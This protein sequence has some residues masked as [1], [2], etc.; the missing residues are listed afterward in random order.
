MGKR[1]TAYQKEERE[2][3]KIVQKIRKFEKFHSQNL[4]ER[5]C[6]R[7]KNLNYQKKSAE[8]K[9]KELQEELDETKKKLRK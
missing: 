2:V 4:I 3:N 8:N 9:I 6:V 5:A 7:Y 1:L